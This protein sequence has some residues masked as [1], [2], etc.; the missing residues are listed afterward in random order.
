MARMPRRLGLLRDDQ[1]GQQPF[2]S[3]MS[4]R[5]VDDRIIAKATGMSSR[6][7]VHTLRFKESKH[8]LE[9]TDL[10]IDAVGPRRGV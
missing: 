6:E 7:Y 5:Q 9:T 2:A 10:P 1:V 3:L 8:V 4:N